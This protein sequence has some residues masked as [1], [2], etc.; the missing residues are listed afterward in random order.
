MIHSSKYHLR[1]LMVLFLFQLTSCH[2]FESP[3]VTTK[4]INE[5]S[6][7]SSQDIGPSFDSCDEL[8]AEEMM[9]CFQGVITSTISDYLNQ[10]LPEANSQIDEEFLVSIIVDQQGNISLENA[11]YSNVLRDALP[12]IETILLDAVYQ[13]PQA[14]PAVKSNVGT[15]VETEFQLPIRILA[16][17][18]N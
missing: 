11:D 16:Q 8:E 18:S 5:A 17:Q 3:A 12:D 9:N 13:L 7:W 4:E 6:A 2:L 1:F 15:Y 14:K 10:N